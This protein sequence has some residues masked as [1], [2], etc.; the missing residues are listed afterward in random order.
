MAAGSDTG[1][2]KV[3]TTFSI[4]PEA[5]IAV[6]KP[7]MTVPLKI[8][9]QNVEEPGPRTVETR[10]ALQMLDQMWQKPNLDNQTQK[11]DK[12]YEMKLD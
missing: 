4:T 7:A 2:W 6:A 8:R 3:N 1:C 11:E 10:S 12:E 9:I 5:G